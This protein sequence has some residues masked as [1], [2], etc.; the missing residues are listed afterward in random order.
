[1]LKNMDSEILKAL[2]G[3]QYLEKEM[4]EAIYQKGYQE[5]YAAKEKEIKDALEKD[6]NDEAIATELRQKGCS[7]DYPVGG[8]V[9]PYDIEKEKNL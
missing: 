3:M 8:L 2:K 7:A 4:A 1:M 5:G 9:E 6:I